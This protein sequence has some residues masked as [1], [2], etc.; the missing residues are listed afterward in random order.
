MWKNG[1]VSEAV[2][3][4]SVLRP[5]AM[6]GVLSGMGGAFGEDC[7]FVDHQNGAEEGEIPGRIVSATVPSGATRT[8]VVPVTSAP[9]AITVNALSSSV[10]V[11]V[12]SCVWLPVFVNVTVLA[13]GC[14]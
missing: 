7:A 3:D 10:T 8:V 9:P 13:A 6:A 14:A 11:T 4:R 12:M 5:L 2:L 1:K